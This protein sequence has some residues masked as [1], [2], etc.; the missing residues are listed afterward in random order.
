MIVFDEATACQLYLHGNRHDT[1]DTAVR[2]SRPRPLGSASSLRTKGTPESLTLNMEAICSSETPFL[3][4]ATRRRYI[5][6]DSI[7]HCCSR[8]NDNSNSTSITS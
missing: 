3:T 2:C 1:G 7:H 6:E 8:E 5:T 4:I